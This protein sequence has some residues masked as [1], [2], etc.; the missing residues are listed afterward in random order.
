MSGPRD[1]DN[2]DTDP[3]STSGPVAEQIEQLRHELLGDL[4]SQERW[5]RDRHAETVENQRDHRHQV[6]AEID[7]RLGRRNLLTALAFVTVAVIGY[8]S[9]YTL[10][11]SSVMSQI[12]RRIDDEFATERIRETIGSSAEAAASSHA[13]KIISD[14]VAPA[15]ED[16][17]KTVTEMTENARRVIDEE[18]IPSANAARDTAT[19]VTASLKQSEA[20]LQHF[21][22]TT[23]QEYR[24][25]L[26]SLR[27]EVSLLNALNR[28]RTLRAEAVEGSAASYETLEE[29]RGDK[30]QRVANEAR[31][32][33]LEVHNVIYGSRRGHL[34]EFSIP[35]GDGSRVA[36]KDLSTDEL[37][38]MLRAPEIW[39]Y[40]ARAAG[41]LAS[42]R[43]YRVIEA[44]FEA[45][46]Q[47]E[48]LWVRGEAIR[49]L[50][51]LA[52][53]PH[54]LAISQVRRHLDQNED[55]LRK[56]LTPPPAVG[57]E[58]K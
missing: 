35:R 37:L 21:I 12:E 55:R 38:E 57:A 51:S 54:T 58:K 4:R 28:V 13:G 11:Q 47:D 41:L 34:N 36:D 5:I 22:T 10:L 52:G 48:N 19:Q 15:V 6:Q 20:E 23:K 45:Y 32:A 33:F 42:R 56:E 40:R 53:A 29:L 1:R 39:P 49:A 44:L 16:A 9:M 50:R 3:S 27:T 2:R 7:R 14:Q 18:V 46:A 30:D 26:E 43:E 8:W 17:R 31:G 25:D 24:E